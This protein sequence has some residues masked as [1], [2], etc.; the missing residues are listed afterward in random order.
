MRDIS[1]SLL[2]V[3]SAKYEFGFSH[4]VADFGLATRLDEA[5]A[6]SG[7]TSIAGYTL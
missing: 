1:M 3:I 7:G 5:G 6:A 4:W 2:A